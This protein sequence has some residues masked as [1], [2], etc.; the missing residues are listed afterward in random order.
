MGVSGDTITLLSLE[1]S[2]NQLYFQEKPISIDSMLVKAKPIKKLCE[3][4]GRLPENVKSDCWNDVDE[5]EF[6]A[7]RYDDKAMN[8][9]YDDF[10][11]LSAKDVADMVF[12]IADRAPH[13]NI[14][15]VLM[16]G[17]QQANATTISRTGRADRENQ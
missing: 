14:Q 8:S 10:K 7:V 11:P 17:T 16:F 6:A 1:Y 12:F 4:D 3:Y 15:D 13:V 2:L 5:T 9:I